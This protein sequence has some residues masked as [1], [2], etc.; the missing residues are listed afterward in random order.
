M[1]LPILILLKG[2]PPALWF[3]IVIFI[4]SVIKWGFNKVLFLPPPE[5]RPDTLFYNSRPSGQRSSHAITLN[6]VGPFHRGLLLDPVQLFQFNL[7]RALTAPTKRFIPIAIYPTGQQGSHPS[8]QN[9]LIGQP[10][11]RHQRDTPTCLCSDSSTT[12]IYFHSHL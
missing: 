8:Q 2:P 11:I 10:S 1:A 3:D 9:G 5:I 12:A 6:A 7:S 4:N